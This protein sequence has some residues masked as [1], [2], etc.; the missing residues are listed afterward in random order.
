MVLTSGY[1]SFC[2]AALEAMACAVPVVAPRVG[3]LPEVVRDGTDG[4]LFEP[5]DVAGAIERAAQLITDTNQ[6]KAFSDSAQAHAQEFDAKRIVPD[7][8]RMYSRVLTSGCG[9]S[10]AAALSRQVG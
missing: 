1:E 7:Y 3:G 6:H 9:S 8:E 2:M 5:G 4:L 10:D